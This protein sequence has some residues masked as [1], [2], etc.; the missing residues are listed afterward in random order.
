MVLTAAAIPA[1]AMIMA[2]AIDAGKSREKDI[3]QRN[4]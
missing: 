2:L 3:S 4:P 1:A